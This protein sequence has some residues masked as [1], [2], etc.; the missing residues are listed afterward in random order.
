MLSGAGMAVHQAAD[1]FEL[2][3]GRPADRGA[4]FRDFDELV[5]AE[6]STTKRKEPMMALRKKGRSAAL[7]ACLVA[8][9]MGLAACGDDDDEGGGGG[10]DA[11]AASRCSWRTATPRR[12]RSTGAV[13]R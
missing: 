5:A 12:S 8:L 10:D 4:M 13:P 1:A 9:P 7:V 11:V 2:I 6:A 3:T